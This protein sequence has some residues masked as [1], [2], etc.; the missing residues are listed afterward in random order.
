MLENK[1]NVVRKIVLN[2]FFRD[3]IIKLFN[4]VILEIVDLYLMS[5][6][7]LCFALFIV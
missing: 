1:N 3:V 4:V 6:I 7:V 5:P 2:I